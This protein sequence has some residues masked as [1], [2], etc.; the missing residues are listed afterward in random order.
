TN[1][2]SDSFGPLT[3]FG[4][5][6]LTGEF[7]A[8]QNCQGA[9]LSPGGSCSVFYTF[10]PTAPGPFSDESSFTISATAN[11]EDG[12]AFS[13]SLAGVGVNPITAAP[14]SHDFGNVNV[15]NTSA[16]MATVITN[17]SS[18]SFGPLTI[19]GGTP[20][21]GEFGAA[22]NCQGATLSPGGSCSVFY[23]FSPTAP[24]PFSGMSDFT[25]SATADQADGEDFSVTLEGCG[26]SPEEPCPPSKAIFSVE[27]NFTDDNP[28]EVE[29]TLLCNTGIPLR[30]SAKLA[31]GVPVKFVV[32]EFASGELDCNV[33]ETAPPGYATSYDDGSPAPDKC[34][35]EGVANAAYLNCMITNDPLAV[36]VKVT[37]QWMDEQLGEVVPEAWASYACTGEMFGPTA[38]TLHFVGIEETESF[39][40][41]PHWN[42]GTVCTVTETLDDPSVE[43]DDHQCEA[44]SVTLNG[45][46]ECTITNTRFYEGIPTLNRLSLAMLALLLAMVGAIGIRRFG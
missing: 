23:N 11:Q 30:Q 42:G 28:A 6:P 26:G 45:G 2:S 29:I 1:T 46:A 10:S 35:F 44:M 5:T 20:L 34:R 31:E 37:K 7:G 21:T 15:G 16:Q 41:V 14:L 39:A 24:G 17:T 25:I 40:V 9:T 13:V 12:E 27:K 18:D 33:M 19:F 32:T 36:D 4:G 22:Q 8:A 3:I 38:G 43:V